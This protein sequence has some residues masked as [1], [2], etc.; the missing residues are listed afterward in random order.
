[1]NAEIQGLFTFPLILY[2]YNYIT[3][4]MLFQVLMTYNLIYQRD[5]YA[6]TAPGIP[7]AV[8]HAD[9]AILSLCVEI[10]ALEQQ[11]GSSA[12]KYTLAQTA[13]ERYCGEDISHC[14][15]RHDAADTD[16]RVVVDIPAV[17]GDELGY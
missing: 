8:L 2:L 10:P 1:M 17:Y 7:E 12:V 14:F 3:R 6:K 5:S 15:V 11:L 9:G 13:D 4:L 16:I